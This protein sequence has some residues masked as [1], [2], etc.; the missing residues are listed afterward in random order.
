[1]VRSL[2]SPYDG[3]DRDVTARKLSRK[4]MGTVANATVPDN[5]WR[6]RESNPRP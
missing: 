6:R 4:G 1:M 3:G 5:W 2:R